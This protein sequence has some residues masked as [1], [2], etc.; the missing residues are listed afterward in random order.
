MVSKLKGILLASD[1]DGT[2][3]GKNFNIPKRNIDSIKRLKK[4]GDIFVL[5]QE[6]Q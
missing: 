3:I 2:L 6:G 4:E 1:L 5:L